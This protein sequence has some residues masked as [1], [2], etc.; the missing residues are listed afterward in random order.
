[1]IP[2]EAKLIDSTSNPSSAFKPMVNAM[3][4]ICIVVI[5]ERAM[6]SR[7]SVFTFV[8]I[9]LRSPPALVT[10]ARGVGE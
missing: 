5:G 1:M 10:A 9:G 8:L 2:G 6:I 3:M 4:I 7:G